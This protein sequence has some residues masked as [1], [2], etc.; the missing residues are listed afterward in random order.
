ME[1][2]TLPSTVQVSD[3]YT[4]IISHL[5]KYCIQINR[6]EL[7]L[8]L[9]LKAN[10]PLILKDKKSHSLA[11]TKIKSKHDNIKFLLESIH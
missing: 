5:S 11:W 2:D 8:S 7:V 6:N 10:H 1:E 4:D 3:T 9:L